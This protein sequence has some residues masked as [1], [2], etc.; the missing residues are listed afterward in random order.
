VHE[1][2]IDPDSTLARALGKTRVGVNSTHHQAVNR[3]A[4]PFRVTARSDDGV[5]L[6]GGDDIDPGIY[7]P[8]LSEELRKTVTCVDPSRDYVEL[9]VIKEV[10]AQRKP[11]LAICRGHQLLNVAFGGDLIVDLPTQQPEA[12]GHN[13]CDLKSKVVHEISIDPDSTLARAL[14]KTRVGVNSTHHQAVNR[15]A[16]PFR[17]TARSDDGVVEALELNLADA[18]L[19]PYL[20]AVQFHPERLLPPNSEHPALFRSFMEAS[21][22]ARKVSL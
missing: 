2:S 17:V 9:L 14:G 12:K 10:F 15:V 20:V 6:S 11:L 8:D 13:R 16:K 21:I 19:L 5:L 1:I 4:K 7:A 18:R 22:S 3:V